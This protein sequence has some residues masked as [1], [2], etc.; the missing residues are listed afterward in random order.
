MHGISIPIAISTLAMATAIM[1]LAI[2][3]LAIAIVIHEVEL[4]SYT[5]RYHPNLQINIPK[6]LSV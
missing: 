4:A 5:F 3:T 6:L 2:A 1:E